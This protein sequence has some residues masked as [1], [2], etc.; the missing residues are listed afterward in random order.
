MAEVWRQLRA[1]LV[2]GVLV[3]QCADAVPM[4]AL[5]TSDL[6]HPVAQEELK[7]WTVRLN[8]WGMAVSQDELATWGLSVGKGA[9]R[10]QRAL[11]SPTRSFRRVTGTGQSWGLFA[12]PEPRAGRLEVHARAAEGAWQPVFV[13]PEGGGELG[14]RL[15]YRRVRG[16][17][18][19]AGDR[20]RPGPLW[21]RT[22]RWIAR[23]VF[24][25]HPEF[26][27]VEVQ[28]V[29]I[30]VVVPG[31]PPPRADRVVHSRLELRSEISAHPRLSRSVP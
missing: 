10:L 27:E 25:E 18:D 1:A 4:P 9:R 14:R 28:M 31:G 8:G 20:P 7:R 6:Q 29:V 11:L 21:K 13:A 23:E 15:R 24:E 5:S 16:L 12:F 2:T 3:A 30:D 17:T 22:T 19:D 26:E